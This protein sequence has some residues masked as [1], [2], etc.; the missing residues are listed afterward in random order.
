M[1]LSLYQCI[2]FLKFSETFFHSANN[3]FI[4]ALS[5][6]GISIVTTPVRMFDEFRS[7][8][9][10][11]KPDANMRNPWFTEYWEN[12]FQCTL[13]GTGTPCNGKDL[14]MVVRPLVGA[15]Q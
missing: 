1:M 3:Y 13:D 15:F 9:A 6:S 12:K 5:L 7:H 4:P 2:F 10:N 8:F 11:L 14:R